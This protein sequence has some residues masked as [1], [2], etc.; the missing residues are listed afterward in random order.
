M[1]V[2]QRIYKNLTTVGAYLMWD[3]RL[4]MALGPA[5]EGEGLEIIRLGGHVEPGEPPIA[6]LK[7]ELIEEAGVA[8]KIIHAPQSFY[9]LRWTARTQRLPQPV[10]LPYQPL[11]VTG[12]PQRSTALFLGYAVAEPKPASETQAILFLR[13]R[14]IAKICAGALTLR[15][16]L[17][18][19]GRV[20][21]QRALDEAQVL[22]AGV[23]LLFLREL[24]EAHNPLVGD[25][26]CGRLRRAR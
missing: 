21:Y 20:N 18:Q 26:L 17:R 25:F 4:A 19:G 15:A 2:Q 9:K 23:H 6:A 10:P 5:H 16:F 12:T 24:S 1:P 22:T 8:A 14:D 13:Q 11:I 3:G 7:R